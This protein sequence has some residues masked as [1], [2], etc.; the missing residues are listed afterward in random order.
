MAIG[1]AVGNGIEM[2]MVVAGTRGQNSK[3]IPWEKF[4][5]KM[6]LKL[7]KGLLEAAAAKPK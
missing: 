2:R 1:H 7:E 3:G 5:I 6:E 4:R